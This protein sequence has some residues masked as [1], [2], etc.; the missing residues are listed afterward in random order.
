M[1]EILDA[2]QGIYNWI[3]NFD[4]FAWFQSAIAELLLWVATIYVKFKIAGI[5][6]FWG[7]AESLIDSLDISSFIQTYW[8]QLDSTFVGVLTRYRIPDAFNL[9]MNAYITR[10]LIS[11]F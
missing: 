10:F 4:L 6:F 1:G 11:L 5:V 9:I 7:I 2:L 3:V 8:G